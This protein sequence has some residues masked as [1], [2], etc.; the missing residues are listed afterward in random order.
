MVFYQKVLAI[1]TMFTRFLPSVV[2]V[3]NVDVASCILRLD[4]RW[5]TSQSLL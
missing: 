3:S 2:V 5:S 4:R 1:Y